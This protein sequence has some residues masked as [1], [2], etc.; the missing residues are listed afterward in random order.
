MPPF[1]SPFLT[2]DLPTLARRLLAQDRNLRTLPA[3]PKRV[4]VLFGGG[5]CVADSTRAVMVSEHEFYPHYYLP[6]DAFGDGVL[7]WDDAGRESVGEGKGEFVQAVLKARE[8][9]TDRVLVF[10]APTGN[11]NDNKT[12]SSVLHG[13]VRVEFAAAE[14]WLEEDERV[15][16]H[17]KNPFKRVDVLFSTRPLR[18]S[19]RGHVIAEA[20]GGCWHLYE[21]GLPVRF[22]LPLTAVK[23]M[24]ML[25]SSGTTT[26]CPYKGVAGYYDLQQEEEESVLKDVVWYYRNPTAEC[27][28]VAGALCFYN[29]KVDIELDGE[30][31]ERPDTPWS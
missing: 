6:L 1:G 22:Y 4:R 29:E 21:T 9:R 19:V 27:A 10:F 17:A 8:G 3:G 18:V 26:Q 15:Y 11:W 31:L 7:E 16:V 28:A 14:A 13:H 25:R 5:C 20:K 23:D 30:K 2:D 12:G 24:T